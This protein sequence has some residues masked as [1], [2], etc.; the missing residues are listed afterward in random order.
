[1]GSVL[2]VF[3]SHFMVG[4]GETEEQM[5][6]AIQKVRDMGGRT[7]LFSFFPEPDSAMA[8]VPPPPIDQ[9]RRIQLARYLIDNRL[10][11]TSQFSFSPEGRIEDFG[12]GAAELDEII[13]SGE[14]GTFPSHPPSRIFKGSGCS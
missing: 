8:H 7:H 12:I 2:A 9:Y 3:G 13:E 6:L 11:D 10:S 1:M 14:P 4:M 5:A